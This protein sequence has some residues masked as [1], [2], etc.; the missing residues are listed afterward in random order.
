M[1]HKTLD[2]VRDSPLM[3]ILLLS[4]SHLEKNQTRQFWI[5]KDTEKAARWL[6][7]LLNKL[8]KANLSCS[9]NSFLKLT[10]KNS[11]LI[12]QVHYL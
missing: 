10:S 6:N 5:T 4:F 2:S 1:Q 7:G 11:A 3:V 12:M 8:L 9:N